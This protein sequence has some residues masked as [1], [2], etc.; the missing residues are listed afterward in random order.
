[1]PVTN[2]QL[3]TFP[4]KPGAIKTLFFTAFILAV[5]LFPLPLFSQKT[6]EFSKGFVGYLGLEQGVVSNFQHLPDYYQVGVSFNPQLTLI[7][8]LLRVG[9]QGSEIYTQKQWSF[10]AGPSLNLRLFDAKVGTFGTVLNVQLTGAFLWG[11]HNEKLVGGGVLT[12]VFQ[13]ISLS[14]TGYR[15]Y[16]NNQ[17]WLQST[18]GYN[19]FKPRK[20][21]TDPFKQL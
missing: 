3:A 13:L 9:V 2:I 14:F 5:F 11:S 16:G 15:D 7:P 21:S 17:W 19:I 6:S 4:E 10:Q 1:M 18:I 20:K 12:E 8:T